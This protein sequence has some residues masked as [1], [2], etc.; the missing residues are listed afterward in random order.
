VKWSWS[1]SANF[2]SQSY[3]PA[4]YKKENPINS[5]NSLDT[6]KP[7]CCEQDGSSIKIRKEEAT[8]EVTVKVMIKITLPK[9]ETMLKVASLVASLIQLALKCYDMF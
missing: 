8:M 3:I 1:E 4:N 5:E 2:G 9:L 6:K 7:P